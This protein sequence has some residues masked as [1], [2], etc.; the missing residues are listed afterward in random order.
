MCWRRPARSASTACAGALLDPRSLRELL[1]G[2]E[3]EA[4]LGPAVSREAVYYLRAG[5]AFKLP[6]T[7]PPLRDHGNYVVSL[8]RLVKWLG[9]KVEAAGV[10]IFTGFAGS[11]LLVEDGGVVGVR[12]D[13]KGLDR[14]NQPKSNFE[15][16]YDLKAKL[17]ILAEG[18]RGSLTK[19]LV[20]RFELRPRPPSADLWRR[21]GR[22]CGTAAGRLQPGEV[23]LHDELAADGE[24][25]GGASIYGGT[26]NVAWV[27][28]GDRAGLSGPR[29][30]PRRVLQEF[31]THPLDRRLLEGGS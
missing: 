30:N 9:T 31:K 19:Q 24:G 13:D 6:I 8:N 11:E 3:T 5:G 10:T 25:Y 2:F 23:G 26:D 22:S 21:R 17:V 20:G 28:I 12:T 4:P 14:N 16:G 1:P 29:L 27:G 15:P 7:P 18:S